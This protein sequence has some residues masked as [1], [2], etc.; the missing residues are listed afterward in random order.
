MEAATTQQVET[1]EK[2]RITKRSRNK[3]VRFISLTFT[4][5][6]RGEAAAV[7]QLWFLRAQDAAKAAELV[8]MRQSLETGISSPK[9]DLTIS[10]NNQNAASR[11]SSPDGNANRWQDQIHQTKR[12]L[13]QKLAEERTCWAQEMSD[14]QKSLQMKLN[15][16]KTMYLNEMQQLKA[17]IATSSDA[18]HVYA[19]TA[20]Y[21]SSSSKQT[22]AQ[23]LQKTFNRA[24]KGEA[25]VR[26][27]IWYRAAAYANHSNQLLAMQTRLEEQILNK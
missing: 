12:S 19:R 15:E 4:R 10:D 14:T 21:L 22:A 8:S 3:A 13:E 5:K 9:S 27:Q 16:E 11:V 23:L 1:R 18:Q 26:V 20:K 6:L 2:T 17:Q 25:G 7:V 24:L